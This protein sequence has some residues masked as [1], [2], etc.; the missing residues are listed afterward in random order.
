MAINGI[1]HFIE[2]EF[3][4]MKNEKDI[5]CVAPV[6]GGDYPETT[7]KL[8]L[9]EG[10]DLYELFEVNDGNEYKVDV[11]TDKYKS[12]I[13]LYFLSKSKL[14]ERK[15]NT[16]GHIA[17]ENVASLNDLQKMLKTFLDGNYYSLLKMMPD[18]IILEKSTNDKYNVLFLGKRDSKTYITKS[19]NLNS[20]AIVLYNF[21]FKLSQFY[22]LINKTE[23]KND[24]D[25]IETL[26]ELYLLG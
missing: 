16:D 18:K 4:V 12:I 14:E 17:V 11:F 23:V 13:A 7:V 20:A 1:Y 10:M 3:K 19:R 2:T 22:A 25:F 9:N 24:D 26:K 15:Y 21:S 6:N 8:T 5:I